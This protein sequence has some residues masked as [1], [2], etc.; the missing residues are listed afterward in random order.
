[1]QIEVIQI[2]EGISNATLTAYIH[3]SSIDESGPIIRP[4]IV[5][6]PGGAYVGI[7]E[8]EADPV[9]MKFLGA[10]YHVFILKYSIGIGIARFPAPFIDAARAM[11]LIRENARRWCVDSDK[12]GLCGFSTGGHVATV[13]ATSWQDA[14]LSDTLNAD[15]QLFKPNALILGYPL[16]DIYQFMKK[17]LE[18]SPKMEPLIEMM[19]SSSYGTLNPSKAV[20][21]EWNC[22]D[23]VS[24]HMPPT[25]L[26]TTVEDNI[27]DVEESL[28]FV[29]T[30]AAKNV[31]FEFHLFE[32]GAHGI[33]LGDET[34]GYSE[35]DMKNHGN[36]NK[37]LELAVSW[38]KH[39]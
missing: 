2:Q 3:D 4:A 29:K 35:L 10:G 31:S 1:M 32:K 5:I 16:L 15:N 33:S 38:L 12:I 26:W 9:A 18:K 21:D 17:N 24:K 19:V 14:Y 22:K 23:L 7:T 13:L 37:W 28:E 20:M 36:A 30:L 25:F 8:K 39:Q 27:V 11:M 34:V 6:F